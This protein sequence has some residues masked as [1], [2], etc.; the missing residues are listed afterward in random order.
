MGS[1]PA[2]GTIWE[3]AGK[4]MVQV[5]MSE[6]QT[7]HVQKTTRQNLPY[8][9]WRVRFNQ[10]EIKTQAEQILVNPVSLLNQDGLKKGLDLLK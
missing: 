3:T 4:T 7:E 9:E 10:E 1:I 2:R 6:G 8:N 5:V